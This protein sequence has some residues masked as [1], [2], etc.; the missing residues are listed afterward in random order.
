MTVVLAL[1]V[2]GRP[3]P[4][5]LGVAGV[6]LGWPVYALHTGRLRHA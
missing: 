6:A 4:A 5:A 2:A 1:L 3:G